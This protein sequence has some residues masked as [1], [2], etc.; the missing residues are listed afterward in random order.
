M[1]RIQFLWRILV[2]PPQCQSYIGLSEFDLVGLLIQI[3][4][5]EALVTRA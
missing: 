2:M 3:V 5:L 1:P 4:F